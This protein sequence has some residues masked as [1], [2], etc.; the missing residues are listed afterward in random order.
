MCLV[1]S[2]I[3]RSGHYGNFGKTWCYFRIARR[4]YD[5]PIRRFFSF[6]NDERRFASINFSGHRGSYYWLEFLL[7]EANRHNNFAKD[8]EHLDFMSSFSR[9][10]CSFTC[11]INKI[12]FSADGY[13][14][15]HF[16]CHK[17]DRS[18]R[19]RW[20]WSLRLRSK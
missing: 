15:D 18:N 11:A 6:Y 12:C 14:Y 1:G 9:N 8:F 19:G 4:F 20:T 3:F 13:P 10:N 5:S 16:G 7:S 17:T 2:F